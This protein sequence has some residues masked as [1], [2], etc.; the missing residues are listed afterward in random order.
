MHKLKDNSV[1]GHLSTLFAFLIWGILPIYW[2][3]LKHVPAQEILAHRVFW[4]FL[5]LLLFN[6]ISNRKRY[7]S[8]F[9]SRKKR[10]SIYLTA[11]LIAVNWLVF[12]LAVTTDHIVDASLGYFI[13]PLVSVLLGLIFLKEKMNL[14]KTIAVIFAFSG[15]LYLAVDY[16]K[17]PWISITLALSFGFYGMFKKIFNL[18]S[19]NSIMLE[20]MILSVIGVGYLIILGVKGEGHFLVHSPGTDT[21]L[22]ISGF[23]TMLP[24]FLFSEGAK[25]IPLASVGFLQYFAPTLMLLIGVFIYNEPLTNTYLVSFILIWTGLGIYTYNLFRTNLKKRR[26]RREK[27]KKI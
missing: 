4:G 26:S 22:V 3:Q 18:D 5:F 13:N 15:V 25:R 1:V 24:L 21:F 10:R 11:A 6:V 2:K 23:V 7:F 17:F 27:D 14:L 19:V 16:G 20:T 8:L 12:I 9:A